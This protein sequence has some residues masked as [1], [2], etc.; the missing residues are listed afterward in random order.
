M[1]GPQ[2]TLSTQVPSGPQSAVFA[3]SPAT[4]RPLPHDFAEEALRLPA[5]LFGKRFEAPA[6]SDEDDE[7]VGGVWEL[8]TIVQDKSGIEY[9][10]WFEDVDATIPVDAAMMQELISSS[11]QVVE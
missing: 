4:P 11:K 5:L 3:P 8:Q 2:L 10:V 7:D 9:Q 6:P 1:N